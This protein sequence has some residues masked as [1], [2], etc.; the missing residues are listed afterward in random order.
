MEVSPAD[1]DSLELID[2]DTPVLANW[3]ALV[4][5]DRDTSD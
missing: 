4:P 3:D 2:K 1:K 5:I